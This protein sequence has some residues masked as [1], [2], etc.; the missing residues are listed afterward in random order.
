MT[1]GLRRVPSTLLAVIGV[2][3]LA[4][5]CAY[6]LHIGSTVAAIVLLLSV[7]L[8]G[9]YSKRTEAITASVVA[10]LCLDYFFMPPIGRITIANPQDW[11]VLAVFLCVSLLSTSLS[12][13]LHRQRDE[14]VARQTET[15][16][17]HA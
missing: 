13:R 17:L 12:S 6:V 8:A 14:L 5:F 15:E 4:L 2:V 11:I 1:V 10:T 3:G 16:K 7:L 9:A